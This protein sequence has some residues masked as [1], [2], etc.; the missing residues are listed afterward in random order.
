[1]IVLGEVVETISCFN[2]FSMAGCCLSVFN[3]QFRSQVLQTKKVNSKFLAS[4]I[5]AAIGVVFLLL[6]VETVTTPPWNLKYH[7]PQYILHDKIDRF[8]RLRGYIKNKKTK[9]FPFP[10]LIAPGHLKVVEKYSENI[11]FKLQQG[12]MKTVIVGNS[13]DSGIPLYQEVTL[14]I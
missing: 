5:N 6:G 7:S 10:H 13:K 2:K 4:W 14:K 12:N 1:M 11:Y 8:C 3:R 9:V